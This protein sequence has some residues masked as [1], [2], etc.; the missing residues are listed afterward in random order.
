MSWSLIALISLLLPLGKWYEGIR[1][2]QIIFYFGFIIQAVCYCFTDSMWTVYVFVAFVL[3][4]IFLS[5][6]FGECDFKNL[7]MVGPYE[8]GYTEFRL[9]N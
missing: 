6:R 4:S 9:G 2:F 1:L 3:C 5:I 7:N 8:V